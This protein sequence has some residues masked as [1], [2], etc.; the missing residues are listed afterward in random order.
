MMTK[1]RFLMLIT[2][3]VRTTLRERIDRGE[4]AL[5]LSSTRPPPP[6]AN[7]AFDELVENISRNAASTPWLELAQAQAEQREADIDALNAHQ[8]MHNAGARG[9]NLEQMAKDLVS[10]GAVGSAPL[11]YVLADLAT[12]VASGNHQAVITTAE[13]VVSL[14]AMQ[15]RS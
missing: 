10:R 8:V 1:E 2:E 4:V 13:R 15:V 11:Q 9:K 6:L 7:N 14:Y 12:A 5:P 3:S